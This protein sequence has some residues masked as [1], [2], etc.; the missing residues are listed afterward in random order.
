MS[1]LELDAVTKRYRDDQLDRIV[2]RDV[3]LQL[4]GGELAVVWGVRGCGRSTLLRVAA[5]IEAPD[6][7][8]VRFDGRD[9]ASHGDGVLG[10]GIGFCQ[11]LTQGG[12]ETAQ[13]VVMLPLLAA[14]VALA[15]AR[16]RAHDALERVGLSGCATQRLAALSTAE[17]VRLSLARV[18][19]RDPRLVVVDDPIQG[20]DLLERDGILALLRSLADD[21]LTVLASATESTALSGADRTLTLSAGELRGPPPHG[22][23]PVVALRSAGARRA[24]A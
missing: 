23:A 11:R 18:L 14:G 20:V 7:G 13:Q 4:D 5:G 10:S 6:A 17:T 8:A 12:S 2:L 16:S 19:V 3:S 21:G 1:L 24:G 9:L 15:G 22:L